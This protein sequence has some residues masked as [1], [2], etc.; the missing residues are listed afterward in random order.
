MS[1]YTIEL[2]YLINS[3]FPIYDLLSDYP[4]FDENHRDELNNKIID[5]F[6]FREIGVETPDR[7]GHHLRTR[8]HEIMPYYNKLY[9]IETLKF[10]PLY[11]F[12]YTETTTG[13]VTHDGKVIT[14][15]KSSD[16]GTG[17][18][19]TSTESVVKNGKTRFE[20]VSHDLGGGELSDTLLNGGSYAT[21]MQITTGDDTTDTT[22]I[23]GNTT[24]EDTRNTES[25][26]NTKTDSKEDSL[27]T[28]VIKGYSGITPGTA[29]Q[30]YKDSIMNIDL[31]VINE[32][33]DLFM[34]VLF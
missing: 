18:G 7:F 15:S 28:K 26:N 12:D 23:T 14:D 24:T 19:T 32:L 11:N 29:I 9:K 10:N 8:M 20:N 33:E 34:S 4:I 27:Y 25:N 21:N 13:N 5:H 22:D 2:R 17:K 16:K 6:Y 30:L 31:M 3:N 1:K